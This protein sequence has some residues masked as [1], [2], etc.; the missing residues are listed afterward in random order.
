[1]HCWCCESEIDLTRKVKLR[2]RRELI[3]TGDYAADAASYAF[4]VKE[5]TYRWAFICQSCYAQLDNEDGR[6][7][8]GLREF[9]LAGASGSKGQ[10]IQVIAWTGLMD[11]TGFRSK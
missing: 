3:S 4:Y 11:K 5:M 7:A 8:I 1:M 9:N 10:F 6:A 2:P